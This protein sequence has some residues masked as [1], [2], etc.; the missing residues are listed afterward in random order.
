MAHKAILTHYIRL[1]AIY[2]T[3]VA[4]KWPIYQGIVKYDNRHWCNNGDN[5]RIRKEKTQ[6]SGTVGAVPFG[7][8]IDAPCQRRSSSDGHCSHFGLG[9]F[10]AYSYSVAY[11]VKGVKRPDY[12]PSQL[13]HE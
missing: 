5:R 11:M 13:H 12:R 7:G 9:V 8:A 1:Y 2:F 4:G 3:I 10:R 6:A